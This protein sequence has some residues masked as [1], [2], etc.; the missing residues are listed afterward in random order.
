MSWFAASFASVLVTFLAFEGKAVSHRHPLVGPQLRDPSSGRTRA[1]RDFLVLG[2]LP[3]PSHDLPG[4]EGPPAGT[5]LS[6][7]TVLQQL[8][9]PSHHHHV[10]QRPLHELCHR[11]S[12]PSSADPV[13]GTF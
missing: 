9:E 7:G 13:P 12:F 2:T 5:H 10:T 4:L 3:S 6:L 11:L 8:L 1:G